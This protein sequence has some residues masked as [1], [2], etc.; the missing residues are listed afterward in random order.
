MWFIFALTA[1]ALF[2]IGQA[3]VKKSQIMLSPLIDNFLAMLIQVLFIAPLM[4]YMGIQPHLIITLLPYALIVSSFFICFY[5]VI[6]QGQVSL[7]ATLLST[8]P[9]IT[10]LLS[11]FFLQEQLNLLQIFA[12]IFIVLGSFLLVYPQKSVISKKHNYSWIVW[13]TAGA[14]L[15]GIADFLVE[16]A[17]LKGDVRTF[18]YLMALSYIPAVT[19]CW[20]F[21]KN[22]RK[23]PRTNIRAFV[24]A[25]IGV[26]LVEMGIVFA[27]LAFAAGSASLV[28]PVVAFQI[29]ITALLA[30]KFLHEYL[31]KS[32]MWGICM[33]FIGVIL[34]SI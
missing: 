28:A 10:V 24:P 15:L 14:L 13:G 27:N 23:V 33:T 1:A 31:T 34:I 19:I 20:F 18:T 22:G 26:T 7:T 32:Q 8:Y 12:I 17:T 2:G 4:W 11:V 6:G 30:V 9:M 3:V 21:D 5:Y 16:I 25:V 29:V